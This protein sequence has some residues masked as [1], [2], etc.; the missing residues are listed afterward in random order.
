[1]VI[2]VYAIQTR[3]WMQRWW[4]VRAHKAGGSCRHGN[5]PLKE[6][7]VDS[8]WP[9][10]SLSLVTE[11]TSPTWVGSVGTRGTRTLRR[12]SIS[13]TQCAKV[14]TR[15]LVAREESA[16]FHT[17]GAKAAGRRTPT[18]QDLPFIFNYLKIS[19]PQ[20]SMHLKILK[21]TLGYLGDGAC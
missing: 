11:K 2:F 15:P 5:E 10:S 19:S 3:R 8:R 18:L 20:M 12:A 1:M 17:P 14:S 13:A 16:L 4:M 7:G 6:T 9:R 21:R